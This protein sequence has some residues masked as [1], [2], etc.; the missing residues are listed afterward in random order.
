MLSHLGTVR[1][2]PDGTSN[3]DCPTAH[4]VVIWFDM[5]ATSVL[6]RARLGLLPSG[7]RSRTHC[8]TPPTSNRCGRSTDRSIRTPDNSPKMNA[9]EADCERDPSQRCYIVHFKRVR[10]QGTKI[11][12][13]E[14]IAT[15]ELGDN[16]TTYIHALFANQVLLSGSTRQR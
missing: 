13:R 9:V 7:C 16:S 6:L 3:T 2:L 8:Q 10:K 11:F 12:R 5:I 14:R 1:P 15:A 4:L